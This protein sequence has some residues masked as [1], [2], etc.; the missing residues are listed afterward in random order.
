MMTAGR[1]FFREAW[2]LS[3]PYFQSEERWSAR[4]RLA[5]IIALNL[6]QVYLLVLLND[7]RGVFYNALQN[8][9]AGV[10]IHQFGRFCILAAIYIATML[11]TLYWLQS[12]QIR[13]RRWLTARY[14]DSWF[15]AKTPAHFAQLQSAALRSR[16]PLQPCA[17][18]RERRKYRLLQGGRA[19]NGST[20][21]AV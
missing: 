20:F 14:L 10:C 15:A 19:R 4:S 2:A 17:R 7:W 12:L 13:W 3:S 6:F 21:A 1:H 5:G 11:L 18:S 9:D 16:L 8:Y